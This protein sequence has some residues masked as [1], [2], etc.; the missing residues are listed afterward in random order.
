MKR[1]CGRGASFRVGVRGLCVLLSLML[2][3]CVFVPGRAGGAS[4]SAQE[5]AGELTVA[6][7]LANVRKAVGHGRL[8]RLRHG[9][10][11]EEAGKEAKAEE[12]KV[13]TFGAAGEYREDT[14][15]QNSRPLGFDGRFG[16][17]VDR[18]GLA[19]HMPQRLREKLLI[20]AWVRGGWWLD[21]RAPFVYSILPE[22]T[23][24]KRVALSMRVSKRGL[25]GAKVFIDRATWLPEAFVVEYERGP[26]T[27]T[28]RDYQE[29]LGFRFPHTTVVN[30]RGSDSEWKVRSVREARAEDTA[31]FAAP[32]LPSDTVFD[33]TLPAELQV[34]QGVAFSPTSPGHYYVRPLVDG[35]DVGWFHFDT[36]GDAM[37]LDAKFADELKMPVLG[38]SQSM[39]A[40]GKPQEVTIRQG[41]TLQLGRVTFKNPIYL[42]TD[43][44]DKNAPPG[45]R[46][47][48]LIG[49]PLLARVVVE[50][51]GGGQK[52][53]LY[54]PATYK[55]PRGRWQELSYIDLTPAVVCR[56]E[57]NREGL[58]QLDT[59]YTGTVTFYDKFI[60]DEK[61]IEGRAVK[62]ETSFGSGGNYKLLTGTVE[63]FEL[64]GVR[65]KQP[66]AGFRV[67]GL[68]REGGAGVVGREFLAPF[69]IVFNYPARRIAF[70]KD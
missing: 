9:F 39:G 54:D 65:F 22:E 47:A 23:N 52:I 24:D 1:A 64:A 46:R 15:P 60:R 30:Y 41:K 66:R 56:F 63:W 26:F 17:Q 67:A 70:L 16:W 32:P 38:R 53:A 28:L 8:K 34:A 36:G 3:A 20:P 18:T 37:Y 12:G 27:V 45:T 42:S 44:S 50:V 69:T 10:V 21:E 61:L 5:S 49:H 57:G 31:R 62:E 6:R 4:A 35:R 11:V 55:L 29:T 51:T 58:F 48:G 7:V 2:L 19:A 68:S 13:L 14:R 43:L 25:V 33:N 40:D 59:G